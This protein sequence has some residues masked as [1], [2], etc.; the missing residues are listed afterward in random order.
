MRAMRIA[1]ARL[2][3]WWPMLALLVCGSAAACPACSYPTVCHFPGFAPAQLDVGA[4]LVILVAVIERPFLTRARI[5]RYALGL[6][7][8]ASVLAMALVGFA[9][10]VLFNV[11]WPMELTFLLLAAANVWAMGM[12]KLWWLRRRTVVD[13]QQKWIWFGVI[14]SSICCVVLLPARLAT[15]SILPT[16]LGM[17]REAIYPIVL[18]AAVAM[19][20]AF[21]LVP[22]PTAE[23][24]GFEVI[25]P[26][27]SG[28]KAT[29]ID[30]NDF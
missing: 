22:R 14:T 25:M 16:T 19:L 10:F 18:T 24:R 7:L 3:H 2:W 27:A 28:A 21:I 15:Q 13:I 8:Q 30:P 26:P 5:D 11:F 17:P 23:G 29:T 20:L 6:S 9:G 12:V 1:G 4:L